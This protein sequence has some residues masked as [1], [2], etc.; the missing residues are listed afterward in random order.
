M[1]P[2]PPRADESD[3]VAPIASAQG[4][5]AWTAGQSSAATADRPDGLSSSP[6]Y[7]QNPIWVERDA[8]LG[9][10]P[11]FVENLVENIREPALTLDALLFF[12]AVPEKTAIP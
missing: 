6:G 3:R 5:Q 1:I 11:T 9:S 2:L 10:S 4:G 12:L 7:S 8:L